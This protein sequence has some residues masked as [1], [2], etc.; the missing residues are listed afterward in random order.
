M[1]RVHVD[2]CNATIEIMLRAAQSLWSL[3]VKDAVQKSGAYGKGDTF[4][5]DAVP[6]VSLR[7]GYNGYDKSVVFVTEETGAHSTLQFTMSDNRRKFPVTD[8]SDPF[9]RSVPTQQ[10]LSQYGDNNKTIWELFSETDAVTNWE[11]QLGAPASITGGCSAVTKVYQGIPIFS[12]IVNFVTRQL[13]VAC[14]AG[15]YCLD[16][17]EDLTKVDLTYVRDNGS[18][19]YFPDINH[20]GNACRFVTFMGKDGYKGEYKDNFE[21]SQLV[22]EEERKDNLHFGLP[23]GPLRPLYLSTL[24]PNENRPGFILSNGEKL[25]EWIHW[26]TFLRFGRKPQDDGDMAL[27]MHEIFGNRSNIRDG[28]LMSPTPPYSLFRNLNQ[29]EGGNSPNS[30][31]LDVGMFP[32]FPVPSRIRST[33]VLAPSDNPWIQDRVTYMGYRR[34]LIHSE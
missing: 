22:T 2:Y 31:I 17:P 34:I 19:I 21:D 29:G 18:R 14:S 10:F 27:S 11:K 15:V 5:L 16:L 4:R 24:H 8:I 12:V 23:G 32:R 30:Y 13:I 26:L 3:K 28:V 9:D 33:L 25:G 20:H 1:Q 6:E 7:T